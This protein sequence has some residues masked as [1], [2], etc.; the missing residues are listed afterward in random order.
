VWDEDG[1]IPIVNKSKA[2]RVIRNVIIQ[3]PGPTLGKSP[4]E[5]RAGIDS[6][7]KPTR[8]DTLPT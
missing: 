5:D 6:V 4:S 8:F 3:L 1:P 2:E 7:D